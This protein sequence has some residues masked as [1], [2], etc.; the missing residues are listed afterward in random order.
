MKNRKIDRRRFIKGAAGAAAGVVS[1]PYVVSSAALGKAGSVAAG[2]RIVV[3]CVGV[4]GHR[5]Q[6]EPPLACGRPFL[7]FRFLSTLPVVGEGART[8][9]AVV[10]IQ[11]M[12][13]EE[14]PGVDSG[15]LDVRIVQDDLT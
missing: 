1:F 5:F 7:D 13:P 8:N 12:L 3:G 2:N 11:T 15:F 6:G 9:D 14:V 4:V 10:M